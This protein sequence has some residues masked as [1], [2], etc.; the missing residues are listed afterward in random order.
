[1]KAISIRQPWASMTAAGLRDIDISN[2]D[3]K[4]RGPVLIVSS[5]RRVGRDFGHDIPPEWYARLR[6]AQALG[7]VPYDEELPTAAVIG[8]AQLND[9]TTD[10]PDSPWADSGCN[11]VLSDARQLTSPITGVKGKQ[12]LYDVP[13]IDEDNL[14]SHFEQIRPWSDYQE[15]V[16]SL[17]MTESE[18]E[19]QMPG[20]PLALMLCGDGLLAPVLVNEGPT[21]SLRSIHTLRLVSPSAEHILAVDSAE[22]LSETIFGHDYPYIAITPA[23]VAS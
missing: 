8:C 7:L 5:A 15:G 6:N 3:T 13:E 16:F 2:R 9:C 22:L 12:G 18:I 23:I 11:W 19:K 4:H 1:M 14:P 10:R 17:A 21:P 20:W